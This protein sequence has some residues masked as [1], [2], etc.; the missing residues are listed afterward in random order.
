MEDREIV[1]GQK[2]GEVVLS[3]DDDRKWQHAIIRSNS[4]AISSCV[5]SLTAV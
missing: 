5:P 2:C 4:D 3:Y 1:R